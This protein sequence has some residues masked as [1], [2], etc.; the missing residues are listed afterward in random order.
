[1]TFGDAA[2]DLCEES[3]TFNSVFLLRSNGSVLPYKKG[4]SWRWSPYSWCKEGRYAERRCR[5]QSEYYNIQYI[6]LRTKIFSRNG[7]A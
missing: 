5:V 2:M 1:M 3:G 7:D 6:Q 4:H